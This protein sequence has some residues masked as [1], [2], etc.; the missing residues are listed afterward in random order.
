MIENRF[1]FFFLVVFMGIKMKEAMRYQK[2]AD[3]FK[4]IL[5]ICCWLLTNLVHVLLKSQNFSFRE[6]FMQ[7]DKMMWKLIVN[8]WQRLENCEYS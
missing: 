1:L 8:Y 7:V 2:R 5:K 6:F 4:K 3:R